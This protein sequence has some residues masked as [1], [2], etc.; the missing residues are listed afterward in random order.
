M[1]KKRSQ[2]II[3]FNGTVNITLN[4]QNCSHAADGSSDHLSPDSG[5]INKDKVNESSRKHKNCKKWK[6]TKVSTSKKKL[7]ECTTAAPFDEEMSNI[8]TPGSRHCE[9][10]SVPVLSHTSPEEECALECI[11]RKEKQVEC[12]REKDIV[13]EKI[14]K[15]ACPF[16]LKAE[17]EDI[18]CENTCKKI[19]PFCLKAE[20][21]DISCE[22]TCKKIPP[23]CLKT[24][25]RNEF[26]K[27]I[28]LF[29]KFMLCYEKFSANIHST[30]KI[31][32]VA[33]YKYVELFVYGLY[34]NMVDHHRH[35]GTPLPDRFQF[36]RFRLLSFQNYPGPGSAIRLSQSGFVFDEIHGEIRCYFC[37]QTSDASRFVSDVDE[38]RLQHSPD[39]PMFTV[40][41][42]GWLNIPLDEDL[43]GRYD[44]SAGI[45]NGQRNLQSPY[46][47]ISAFYN[48]SQQTRVDV[49]INGHEVSHFERF[50][51]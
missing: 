39:C 44:S 35:R 18:L 33:L 19:P 42:S 48:G 29:V 14:Y 20:K 9:Q 34:E 4:I 51:F 50:S 8:S 41:S 21:K 49:S 12:P 17:K 28:E 47:R 2:P 30:D 11:S 5:E 43:C 45:N 13:Q 46:P 38:I 25:K 23:F 40:E 22:N 16:Y 3:V 36:E 32:N 24:D 7:K 31:Y 10:G 26:H 27:L 15:K 37:N 1:G 6:S